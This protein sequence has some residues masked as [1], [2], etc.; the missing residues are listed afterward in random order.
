MT[1][2][3]TRWTL[4]ALLPSAGPADLEQ[5][6]AAFERKVKKVE[7]WRKKL[8]PN[9]AAKAFAALL[10]DYEAMHRDLL[11]INAFT[12]LRFLADTQDQ[13]ALAL[14]T[15][16]D[17]L[18]AETQNRVLF[19]SLWWKALDNANARRLLKVA[20]D[21]RYWLEMVRSFR[22]HTLS[23]AEE[24][25]INLKDV[26]GA[27]ALQNLYQT[28]TNKLMF[29]LT[30]DGQTKT[31]T[32]DALMVYARDADPARR[33]AAYQELYRVYSEHGPVLAQIYGNLARNWRSENL[34][35]RKFKAPIAV[36]NLAN[37]VPDRVVDTL[38]DVI[39]RNAG[40]F[41]RYFRLKAKWLGLASLRRYDI[42]APLAKSEKPY[43][44]DAAVAMVLDTFAEFSPR[45]GELALR[46]FNEG[47]VDAEVRPGKSS[48]AFCWSVLPDMAPWVLVNY[49]G[50]A[51]DVA[52][53]AHEMGHG[54]HAL[55]AAEHSALTFHSALPMAETASVFSEMMLT[56]KLLAAEPDPAVRRDLLAAALDD[57]YATVGRQG[58]FAMWEK[59]AHEMVRNNATADEMAARYLETL[60]TQFGD[61]VA[62]SDEFKW[63]WVCIPHFYATPFYVYAYSFGQLLVLSLYEMFRREG[64]TFKPKYLKILSHGGSAS[65]A[66]ILKEAGID[67]ASADFWQGGYNVIVGMIDRLEKMEA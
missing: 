27:L 58:F 52:V 24:K 35:L 48:G 41:Q 66:R 17:E 65:P 1:Y 64:Q 55:L 37:D 43:T 61:A 50:K 22:P 51:S 46:V 20:G 21:R 67:I 54:I 59:E 32:R 62:V 26:S 2:S 14:M 30:L 4:D 28:I 5:A 63:E 33:A 45:V 16:V 3:Q 9:L 29:T 7:T 47:H 36:R 53:L 56:E 44:Y 23:E 31:L 38:L 10:E 34:G 8:K 57:A 19:F 49:N 60:K 12:N 25:V 39:A 11:R 15:R 13:A 42:Y 18:V 40:V 6:L